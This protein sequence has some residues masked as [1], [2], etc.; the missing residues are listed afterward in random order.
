[1]ASLGI[2][3]SEPRSGDGE[4]RASSW[5]TGEIPGTLTRT[6][7][8]H[9]ARRFY[10]MFSTVTGDTPKFVRLRPQEVEKQC[11]TVSNDER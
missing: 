10:A 2:A 5:V 6:H 8:S 3:S 4:E 1:V 9:R 11:Q 7:R